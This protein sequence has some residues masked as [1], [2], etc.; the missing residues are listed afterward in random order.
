MYTR[1]R[2]HPWEGGAHELAFMP[3][4]FG[5][6]EVLR[7]AAVAIHCG[8]AQALA[9]Y[10]SHLCRTHLVRRMMLTTLRTFA[11]KSAGR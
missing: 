10:G 4:H 11:R 6:P 5:Q 9:A 7:K 8:Q 2:L 3:S 1:A